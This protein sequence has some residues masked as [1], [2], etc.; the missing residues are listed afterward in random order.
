VEPANG[1]CGKWKPFWLAWSSV[2][3]GKLRGFIFCCCCGTTVEPRWPLSKGLTNVKLLGF[4]PRRVLICSSVE[5]TLFPAADGFLKI[6]SWNNFLEASFDDGTNSLYASCVKPPVIILPFVFVRNKTCSSYVKCVLSR[7]NLCPFIVPG[8][9]DWGERCGCARR[10]GSNGSWWTILSSITTS[11]A[12]SD[13]IGPA[14]VD[15]GEWA[16]VPLLYVWSGQPK[17]SLRRRSIKLYRARHAIGFRCN[18][19]SSTSCSEYPCL[20]SRKSVFRILILVI[21]TYLTARYLVICRLI[22]LTSAC[23][24]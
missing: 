19:A 21:S 22:S 15:D 9:V 7:A 5:S 24:L 13:K 8:S 4:C 17:P 14:V 20:I 16:L 12:P 18:T 10:P 11:D 2:E 1:S 23:G 6:I 3:L